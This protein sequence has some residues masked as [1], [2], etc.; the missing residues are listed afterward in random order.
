MRR[1]TKSV[2]L[3]FAVLAIV[4]GLTRATQVLYESPQK[5]GEKSV[6]VVQGR[7]LGTHSYWNDTKTKIYT[8]TTVQVDAAHKGTAAASVTVLQLG[9][10]VDNVRMTVH[11]ALHWR[12]DEEVVVFLEP[13]TPGTY[14]VSGFS[15]GKFNIE[16]DAAGKAFVKWP[17][18]E[19]VEILGAPSADGTPRRLDQVPLERFLDEALGVNGKGGSR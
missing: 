19:D 1:F 12:P 17:S 4:A 6:L 18:L 15:Q 2:V 9:G 3:S 11:G 16:R 7:V 14:Q 13:C 8:E 10:I 5:M